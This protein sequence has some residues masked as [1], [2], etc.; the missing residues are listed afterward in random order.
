MSE[1]IIFDDIEAAV[2]TRVRAELVARSDTATVSNEGY[3]PSSP[4]ERPARLVVIQRIGGAQQSLVID[5]ATLSVTCYDSTYAGAYEL[6]SLVRGII[7]SLVNEYLSG[8]LVTQVTDMSAPYHLPHSVSN[9]PR[10]DYSVRVA[11]RGAA[12]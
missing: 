11:Y 6:V 10:Y 3:K 2:I 5:G 7:R 4:T 1:V 8:I 12:E 9:N